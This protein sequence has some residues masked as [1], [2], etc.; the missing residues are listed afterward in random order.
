MHKMMWLAFAVVAGCAPTA[1][2]QPGYFA[3]GQPVQ[4][5]PV[6]QGPSGCTQLLACF[7]DCSQDGACIQGCVQQS[8]ATAQSQV[9]AMMQC[10]SSRCEGQGVP[11]PGA[12]RASGTAVR[13]DSA[14]VDR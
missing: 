3:Q 10:G 11:R 7:T 6:E 4:Q 14:A 9:Q 1:G 13:G 12:G 2:Q 5:Q 8:D